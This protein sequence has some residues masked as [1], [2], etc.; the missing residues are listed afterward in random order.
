MNTAPL[1]ALDWDDERFT[2][3]HWR[4][5]EATNEARGFET[6]QLCARHD[7][8]GEL[9][10]YTELTLPRLWPGAAWQEDTGVWPKHRERGLGRWLKA[11]NALRLLD[12]RPRWSSS[13]RGTPAA[14]R[15]CSA[16]TWPWA[17]APSR[18]GATGRPPPNE[19]AAALER[20]RHLEAS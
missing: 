18:T 4:A 17:S 1:E 19:V 13:T 16:S 15:R 8:S 14:T 5:I 20:R 6:W 11:V 12:E 3:E 7:D 10:G 9:A 2:A